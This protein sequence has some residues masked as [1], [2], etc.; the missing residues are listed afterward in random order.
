LSLLWLQVLNYCQYFSW[1]WARSLAAPVR[2]AIAIGFFMLGFRGLLAQRRADRAAW[3][4]LFGLFLVTGLG[5][6]AYMNFRPGFSLG[7]DRYPQPADHE[8]RERDYFFV[9]SFIVWGIWAGLGLAALVRDAR[10]RSRWVRRIAPGLLS[11]ACLPI[12]LNWSSASRRSGAD[13]YLAADFAYNL[14]NSAP[15]YGVLFT[16]GDN[17]TFPLWWAQEVQ[18]I[19]QDVTVICLALA[20]TDWYMRQLRDA[21]T[22]PVDRARL[23][24]LW[25]DSVPAAPDWP[26]HNMTDSMV[27]SA[28]YGY[29][30]SQPQQVSLGPLKRT[31]EQGTVLYPSDILSLSVIQQNLGRRPISWGVATGRS[32]A[33][34]GEYIV[35]QG[36][37]FRLQTARPDTTS[38]RL[39][40]RRLAG[41]PMDVA[42]TEAL[43]W[44]TYRYGN[45]LEKGASGLE[46]TSASVAASLAL[47]FVEL[48][49]TYQSRG[50]REKMD[51]VLRRA[52]K[53]S[54]N[55]DLRAA[56]L[57]LL[58]P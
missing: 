3:V 16:Y 57:Q 55:P 20:N 15:P 33:G 19:R 48:V 34:L 27:A 39:D 40:F 21:R 49:Y 46:P 22:R 26:L 9:V 43:V 13:A 37:G 31:L 7:F 6:V 17:D 44:Q 28:M 5:L 52:E 18:G 29:F 35:Q 24:V 56:L 23:P 54:P 4:L 30:V 11:L 2:A 41:V 38:P 1:Q 53:L 12:A 10:R 14:L 32:F 36:L 51:R 58:S 8:V 47:P 50:E 25:R 45:L 42:T